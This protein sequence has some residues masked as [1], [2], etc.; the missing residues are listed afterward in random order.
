MHG[1][2]GRFGLP[3]ALLFFASPKKSKQKKGKG[4]KA[5]FVL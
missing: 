2:Q 3:P 1:L 4:S 5:G